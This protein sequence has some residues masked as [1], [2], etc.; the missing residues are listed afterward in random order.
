MELCSFSSLGWFD[1]VQLDM[2]LSGEGAGRLWLLSLS[3]LSA[4]CN[5]SQ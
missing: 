4:S 3:S 5:V 1:W 2:E